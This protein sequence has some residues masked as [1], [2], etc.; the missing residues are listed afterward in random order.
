[1]AFPTKPSADSPAFPNVDWAVDAT[2]GVEIIKPTATIDPGYALNQVVPFTA[3]NW[4][5]RAFAKWSI[6]AEAA[7]DYFRNEPVLGVRD[8]DKGAGAVGA[9][10]QQYPSLP[11]TGTLFLA[12]ASVFDQLGQLL[13]LIGYHVDGLFERHNATA[14]DFTPGST[15][16]LGGTESVDN[17]DAAKS[18][19]RKLDTALYDH[20]L[21]TDDVFTLVVQAI[22][23][24]PHLPVHTGGG[25]AVLYSGP[26]VNGL[27]NGNGHASG[28]RYPVR[29][30]THPTGTE[31][32]AFGVTVKSNDGGAMT[33]T[34]RK[35]DVFADGD[36][37]PTTVATSSTSAGSGW[38]LI[39]ATGLTETVT[40]GEVWWIDV[41]KTGGN[42]DIGDFAAV[43]VGYTAPIHGH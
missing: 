10:A 19:L 29:L 41:V 38:E 43:Y 31:I 15:H 26:G 40:A 36:A 13:F 37:A 9:A 14:I 5:L 2:P 28:V 39:E 22:E 32:N 34:L 17:A 16:Y 3:F 23:A 20:T 7:V 33:A 8:P 11:T 21:A 25:N 35:A 1:M 24:V 30:P 42:V 6:W 27:W 18:A 12:D 4:I